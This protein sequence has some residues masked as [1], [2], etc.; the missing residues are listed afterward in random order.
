MPQNFNC[1]NCGAPL[2]YSGGSA[3]TIRCPFCNNSVIVPEELR[4]HSSGMDGSVMLQP[5]KLRDIAEL[6]RAGDKIEAIRLYRAAF[7]VGLQDAKDA[8]EALAAGKPVQISSV[9]FDSSSAA[10]LKSS[11]ESVIVQEQNRSVRQS[12]ASAFVGIAIVVC[13]ILAIAL[14]SLADRGLSQIAQVAPPSPTSPPTR[15]PIPS[16][17]PLPTPTPGFASVVL[18]FGDKGTGAGLFTDARSIALDA[19]GNIY[20]GDYTGGR[21]QVFDSTGKYITQWKVGNSKTIVRA[22]AADRKGTVYVVADGEIMRVEGATGKSLGSLQYPDGNRFDSIALTADGGLLAMWYEAQ[23]GFITSVQGH[24]D[25]LVRFDANGKVTQVM[26][27]IISNQTG[28][29]ELETQLAVDGLG[30]IYALGGSFEH[31]V[32]KFTL[33]GKF[34]NKFGSQGNEPGQFSFSRAIAVDNQSRVYVSDNP[35]IEVFDSNGRYLST[36]KSDVS[37]SAM[38]FNDQ[39]ELFGVDRT[40]VVKFVLNQR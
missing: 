15:T 37:P 28:D 20:V 16:A 9:T 19:A 6:V 25:D 29:P 30:T 26:R 27:G 40:Q 31:G 11:V 36:F 38:M 5:G 3:P 34:V 21:V 7:N 10:D 14:V 1:P 32:F 13:I 18:R 4:D 22:L 39:N 12:K 24:R 33:E 17:T 2:D 8:V 35:G 23:F